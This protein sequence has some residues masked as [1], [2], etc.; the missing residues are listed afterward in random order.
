MVPRQGLRI[1]ETP[2]IV[3]YLGNRRLHLNHRKTDMVHTPFANLTDEE[4]IL[5]V[6]NRPKVTDLEL[7]LALRVEQLLDELYGLQEDGDGKDA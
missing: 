4:L 6:A 5:E 1:L 7:E 2:P 3:Y